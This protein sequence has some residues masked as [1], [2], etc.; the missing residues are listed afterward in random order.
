MVQLGGVAGARAVAEL[1]TQSGGQEVTVR[2]VR[3]R[4]RNTG[5]TVRKLGAGYFATR[6]KRLPPVL[7]W[8]EARLNEKGQEPLNDLV[9]AILEAYPQGD[10]RA[11][12]AWIHQQPGVLNVRDNV[13]YFVEGAKVVVEE[14]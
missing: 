10:E 12:Y 14:Y 3:D 13:V 4:F 5:G 9:A 6:Q 7:H 1:L 2:Q 8:V 11:I